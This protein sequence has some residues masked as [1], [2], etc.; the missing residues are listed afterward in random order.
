MRS[1]S[2]KL[3]ELAS[4]TELMC[5]GGWHPA[6]RSP[7]RR[8]WLRRT[9]AQDGLEGADALEDIIG[10]M[11]ETVTGDLN[12][13][14][15][16]AFKN[17]KDGAI[18][19]NSGHFNSEINIKWLEENCTSKRQLKPLVEQYELPDGRKIILLGE[20]RL[21]TLPALKG[22]RQRLWTCP[23]LTRHCALSTC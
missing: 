21:V 7:A 10:G 3:E 18:I 12:V 2:G 5:R 20:G 15:A 9:P 14:G 17:M 13:I 23:L 19:S 11:E 22:T 6:L 16:S 4:I 1:G 8:L